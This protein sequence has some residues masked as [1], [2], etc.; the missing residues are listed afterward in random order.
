[1]SASVLRVL[2]WPSVACLL[3]RRVSVVVGVPV[4][5]SVMMFLFLILRGCIYLTG[6]I[7]VYIACIIC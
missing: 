1:M 6:N 3:C 4:L 2:R 5:V 7:H